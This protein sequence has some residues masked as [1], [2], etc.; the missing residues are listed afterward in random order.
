MKSI[1]F[2]FGSIATKAVVLD[3][4][5]EILLALDRRKDNDDP[6]AID[7]F[8]SD[9]GSRF[10]SERF[11]C[12]VAGIESEKLPREIG[13]INVLTAIAHGARSVAPASRTVI[14]IGGHT[15]K[16]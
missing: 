5:G 16:F 10:P 7:E 2:D 3:G 15:S 4:R 8:L 1:G 13:A 6:L 12:A 11:A 9:L 14:E